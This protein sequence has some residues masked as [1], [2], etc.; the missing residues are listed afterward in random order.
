METLLAKSTPPR[1]LEEHIQD[2][3]L[4]LS[5]LKLSFPKMALISRDSDFWEL[6]E[7][8]IICHDLGKSHKEFQKLLQGESNE[9][10]KQRH[11]LF[12]LPFIEALDISED[13]KKRVLLVV[14]AH[15]RSFDIEGFA[16]R[17]DRLLIEEVKRYESSLFDDI[18]NVTEE[19]KSFERNFNKNVNVPAAMEIASSFGLSIIRPIKPGN[20]KKIIRNFLDNKDNSLGL[21][22]FFGALKHCDHMGS[23]LLEK[24]PRIEVTDL[25]RVVPKGII[26]YTHQLECKNVIG[27]AILTSPTGSGKTESAFMWLSKQFQVDGGNNQGRIFYILPF[28]ASINAM[29]ERVGKKVDGVNWARQDGKV[30]LIHGKLSAYLDNLLEDQQF[31]MGRHKELVKVIRNQ[32]RS[33]VTPLKVVTPFQLLK[34]LFGLKGFEQGLLELSGSYLVFDE[35]H[36]YSPEVFAQIKVLIEFTTQQLGANV[37]IMT[38]TLPSFLKQDLVASLKNPKLISAETALFKSFCRHKVILKEGGI[39]SNINMIVTELSLPNRK[40]LVVCNT[41]PQAQKVFKELARFL[42]TEESVLLHG[43]FNAKDRNYNE[44]K[45]LIEE[46]KVRLLVGTQAIEVSL[47]IDFDVIYTEA[48]PLDALI[49]R[50]GRVNRR[51]QKGISNCFVFTEIDKNISYIYSYENI[52]NTIFSFREIIKKNDGVIDESTLQE[53]IDFVYPKWSEDDFVKYNQIYKLLNESLRGLVPFIES[54]TKEEDFYK[55]FDGISILPKSLEPEFIS[56]LN[57]REFIKAESL[58]VQIR[59]NTYQ[60]WIQQKFIQSNTH[61][62]VSEDNR[63]KEVK[64]LTTNKVYLHDLGL[65]RDENLSWG[66]YG[67]M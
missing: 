42:P 47:D 29:F 36:A 19:D 8:A 14:A 4:I 18:L 48:A 6:L 25:E 12:S 28:T 24:L 53:L 39:A 63:L 26:P 2:C 54:P 44:Q 57:S 5:E 30:G 45:L 55:Q 33:I 61:V 56:L 16:S 50:F 9:W 67:L 38:A 23:A 66:N 27:H 65:L 1:R 13:R 41:V 58:K 15:H 7:I 10:N 62:L 43:A 3:L 20:P 32:F 35:I 51:R 46:S 11:E 34:H 59:K 37:F 60:Y 64:Y 22:L 21:L 17:H 52:E 31:Q 49:Q 40:V